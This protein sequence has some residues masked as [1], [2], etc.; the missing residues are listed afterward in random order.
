[1]KSGSSRFGAMLTM[2]PLSLA[3][4]NFWLLFT[5]IP[6]AIVREPMVDKGS[7]AHQPTDTA[8]IVVETKFVQPHGSAR[9]AI[10][11]QGQGELFQA[12]SQGNPIFSLASAEGATASGPM[13]GQG[14]IRDLKWPVYR[15]HSWSIGLLPEPTVGS[16][17]FNDFA[18]KIRL[19]R[20]LFR[21]ASALVYPAAQRRAPNPDF[22]DDLLSRNLAA[23]C[24]SYGLR[25]VLRYRP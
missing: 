24:C 14:F 16:L 21:I 6:L 12:L 19:G 1:M 3:A 11:T 5:D 17:L 8:G 18:R 2:S 13:A 9:A 15:G 4:L 23:E 22:R 25:A 7:I 10:A 20:G